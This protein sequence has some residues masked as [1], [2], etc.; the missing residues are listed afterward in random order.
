MRSSTRHFTPFSA[1]APR[2]NA[3]PVPAPQADQERLTQLFF[4]QFNVNALFLCDQAVLSLY[5]LGKTSGTVIDLGH[6]K[7]GACPPRPRHSVPTGRLYAALGCI[8]AFCRC[9]CFC[10]GRCLHA[11]EW[12]H[13]ILWLQG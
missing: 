7:V 10:Q 1:V 2:R 3:D 6:G 9:T 12:L 8:S 13:G 4:E 11:A 5:A